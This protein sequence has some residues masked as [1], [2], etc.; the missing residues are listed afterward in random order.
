MVIHKTTDKA[1]DLDQMIESAVTGGVTTSAGTD[2]G[3]T[4]INCTSSSI[5]SSEP[6]MAEEGSLADRIFNQFGKAVLVPVAKVTR[7]QC[8]FSGKS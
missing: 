8:S 2:N 7:S 4:E 6:M 5:D 3:V 1:S